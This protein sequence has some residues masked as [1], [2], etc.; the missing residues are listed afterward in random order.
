MPTWWADAVRDA[1]WWQSW[2]DRYRTFI[3]NYADFAEQNNIDALILGERHILPSMPNGVIPDGS[4]SNVFLDS[5]ARWRELVKDVKNRY[6]GNLIL[7]I[8]V[9]NIE[10]IPAVLFAEFDS[11]YMNFSTLITEKEPEPLTLENAIGKLLDEKIAP[12]WETTQ[13]PIF[14][15][16]KY[17]SAQGAEKGCIQVGSDCLPFE[18][19]DQPVLTPVNIQLDFETQLEIYEAMMSAINEREW[20]QGVVSQGYFP[21]AELQDLS[22][23]IHGKPAS[24]VLWYWYP[25][26]LSTQ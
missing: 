5:E 14:I 26:F 7:A 12:V 24:A 19:L 6:H 4:P 16:L 13:K 9:D 11:I 17:P 23:S 20:I 15:G 25:R 3:L 8:D 10:K 21:P 18:V 1:G 2:F 22:S